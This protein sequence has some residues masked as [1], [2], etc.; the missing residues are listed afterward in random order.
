MLPNWRQR[1][2]WR[3]LA[4][5]GFIEAAREGFAQRLSIAF[6]L[7][8]AP[9]RSFNVAL[10]LVGVSRAEQLAENLRGL[11]LVLPEEAVTTLESAVE[12]ERGFPADFIAECEASPFAFGE[13]VVVG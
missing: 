10:P 5:D 3:G 13:G 4:S 6:H 8:G 12:F 11:D 9:G 1:L 2:A 7:P